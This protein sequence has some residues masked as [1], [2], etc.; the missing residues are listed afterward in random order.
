MSSKLFANKVAEMLSEKKAEEIVIFDIA[1]KSSFADYMI[2]ASGRNERQIGALKEELVEEFAKE[3]F[4]IKG[5]E[6]E[7]ESGW[8]LVDGGD[9]I[10]SLLTEEQRQNYNIESVWADCESIVWED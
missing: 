1:K 6:G 5:V 2:L 10:I 8:I 7:K 9:L 4:D 3:G